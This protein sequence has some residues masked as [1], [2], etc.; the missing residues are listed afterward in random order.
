LDIIGRKAQLFNV[1]RIPLAP[2]ILVLMLASTT[3][4]AMGQSQSHP[5]ASAEQS[6]MQRGQQALQAGD[7]S[8]ARS[9]FEKAVRLAP[10]DA[11]AQAALGWV[12]MQFGEGDGAIAHLRAALNI[13]PDLIEAQLTLAS[14]LAQQGKLAEGVEEARSATKKAPANAEA[15]RTLARIVS[16][17]DPGEALAEMQRAV[18]LAP[19]RANLRDE[20]G[21]VMAQ[22]NQF[23][24]AEKQ[25]SEALRLDPSLESVE[26]S[27]PA[28]CYD[29]ATPPVR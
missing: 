23:P 5:T 11:A 10:K 3:V 2:A 22:Q 4:V 12:L 21:T 13:R 16:N 19:Q 1:L 9:E 7:L 6:A 25:F 15:H 26:G 18:E 20:L 14:V 8:R 29:C 27:S 17:S 24:E 28:S